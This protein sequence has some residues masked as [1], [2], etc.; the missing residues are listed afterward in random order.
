MR[1]IP[2]Q[3]TMPMTTNTTG[4]EG[5]TAAAM[6]MSSSSD[7]KASVTSATRMITPSI[8]RP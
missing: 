1:A 4:N 2:A 7:G 6:A 5:F 8:Q 3:P